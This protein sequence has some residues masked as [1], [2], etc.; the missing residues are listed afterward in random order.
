MDVTVFSIQELNNL[1][2]ELIE[3]DLAVFF[4]KDLRNLEIE[5]IEMDLPCSAAW[6]LGTKKLS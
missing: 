6:S 5:L 2:I 1:E 3:M 4:S